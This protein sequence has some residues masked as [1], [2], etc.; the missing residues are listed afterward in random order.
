MIPVCRAS[1]PGHYLRRV[2]LVRDE[3]IVA[4]TPDA[5][6][7]SVR[8]RLYYC[9]GSRK[10]LLGTFD[11]GRHAIAQMGSFSLTGSEPLDRE[12]KLGDVVA[13]DAERFGDGAPSLTGFGI[14]VETVPKGVPDA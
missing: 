13:V 4:P 7:P 9:R 1:I 6:A 2:V 5:N 10:D 14:W 11:S 3:A 8:I 12:L